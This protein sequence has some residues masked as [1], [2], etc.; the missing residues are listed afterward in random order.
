[1]S[2]Y[3]T[4]YRYRNV[5]IDI[6]NDIIFAFSGIYYLPVNPIKDKG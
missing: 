4:K 3:Y 5:N 1:M 2:I 6:E